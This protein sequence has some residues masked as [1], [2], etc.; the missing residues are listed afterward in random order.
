MEK[1]KIFEFYDNKY[2][3]VWLPQM[4]CSYDYILNKLQDLGVKYGIENLSTDDIHPLQN[5]INT[6][7]VDH[8]NN[9]INNKEAVEPIFISNNNE[10]MD[11]HHRYQAFKNANGIDK[12][13]TIKLYLD[14]K[15]AARILNKI[16]DRHEFENEIATDG[17]IEE[18]E[19]DNSLDLP[20]KNKEMVVY[21]A[22]PI[23]NKSKSGNFFLMDKKPRYDHEYTLEFDNLYEIE[24]DYFGDKDPVTCLAEKWFGDLDTLKETAT[25]NVLSFENYIYRKVAT[26]AANRGYDGI[27]YGSKYIQAI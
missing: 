25:K 12:I 14:K 20:K 8:F 13:L 16:Q 24:D 5:T 10:I 1:R 2:Q 26:E 23:D 19:L 9:K 3:P 17:Q 6:E 21:R 18:T 27:K 7:T 15:D 11:G 4:R 22:K